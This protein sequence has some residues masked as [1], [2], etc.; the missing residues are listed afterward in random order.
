MPSGQTSTTAPASVTTAI[1]MTAIAFRR[2][3]GKARSTYHTRSRSK[4]AENKSMMR[5]VFLLDSKDQLPASAG[6][7][8]KETNN[9]HN[10]ATTTTSANSLKKLPTMPGRSEIG[11][12]TTQST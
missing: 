11:K 1:A 7:M 12:K 2:P 9:E 5:M 10:V 3:H 6:V 4:P 8:V